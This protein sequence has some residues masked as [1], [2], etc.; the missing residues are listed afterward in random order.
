[1]FANLTDV[2]CYYELLG[3]GDPVLLVP[4]LGTT[5]ALWD[6]V[7]SGLSNSFHLILLDNRGVGRS[8]AKRTPHT[9]GDF[10][11]DL[12][13]LL[14]HL[15]LERV[16]V[17][18]ISLGGMIAQ[19]LAIDHASRVDRLVL[20]SCTNRFGP[21]L[22]EVAKLLAHALRH[23]K[24]DL[25]RRTVELLGTAPQF[26]DD[27]CDEIEQLIARER[28]DG[29]PR[30]A[31]A[32][33]LR[34]LARHDVDEPPDFHITAPTLVVA[35]QQDMLIPA[36]Y[37]QRMA[38]E[39]PGSEFVLIPGCGHNPFTEKPD[40]MITHITQFLSRP[41]ATI[42]RKVMEMTALRSSE[43]RCTDAQSV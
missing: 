19:Q 6:P 2:R 39:I 5:C 41:R 34:C 17:I 31:L 15:Q 13:E 38:A 32:R 18:G 7:A 25:F 10:A 30:S 40:V 9:L 11:I 3:T 42:V 20:V 37:A 1:M 24:P 4:G 43:M 22:R 36:C 16:H 21:Y 35:G 8:A 23:F 26:L 27:H 28:Y 14:D 12:V 33:Q 29:V